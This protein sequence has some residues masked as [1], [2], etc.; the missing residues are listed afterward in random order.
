[1]SHFSPELQFLW[2]SILTLDLL[3]NLVFSFC[4]SS[5]VSQILSPLNNH[6][7]FVHDDINT[8]IYCSSNFEHYHPIEMPS[9][10]LP[11][12]DC[13]QINIFLFSVPLFIYPNPKSVCPS[14]ITSHFTPVLKRKKK[15]ETKPKFSI[16]D[17]ASLF[18]SSDQNIKSNPSTNLQ[19]V[20]PF[21]LHLCSQS[22]R[23]KYIF[24]FHFRMK[25][26]WSGVWRAHIRTNEVVLVQR[27]AH[28]PHLQAHKAIAE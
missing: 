21:G 27:L 2:F 26:T 13:H 6:V 20:F 4:Q 24:C 19:G 23:Q 8:P 12:L 25:E 28:F 17:A 22:L 14:S 15:R 9:R 10:V 11:T 16:S 18:S 1:M 7:L 3:N 5:L